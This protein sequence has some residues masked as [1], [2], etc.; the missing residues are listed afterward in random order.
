VGGSEKSR[1]FDE[2]LPKTLEDVFIVTV[3]P[4]DFEWLPSSHHSA[5]HHSRRHHRRPLPHQTRSVDPATPRR[6]RCRQVRLSCST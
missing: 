4:V 5:L 2:P 1:L 6:C 3:A